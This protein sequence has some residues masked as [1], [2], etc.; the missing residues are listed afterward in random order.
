MTM[1]TL[2]NISAPRS[3]LSIRCKF[4]LNAKTPPA[5]LK[6]ISHMLFVSGR[7]SDAVR[8]RTFYPFLLLYFLIIVTVLF[9]T[10]YCPGALSFL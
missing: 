5:D 1:S 3:L 8:R 4:D 10:G 2:T 7:A 9:M 6:H